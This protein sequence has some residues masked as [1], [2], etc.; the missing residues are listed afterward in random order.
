[1]GINKIEVSVL[2]AVG[3]ESFKENIVIDC[4]KVA[5]KPNLYIVSIG[6]SNYQESKFNLKYAS[7]DAQD[8]ALLFQKN[9]T[10]AKVHSKTLSDNE[11]TIE[12]IQKI[13]TF[14]DSAK[15]S[16]HVIIF[17]AGHGVL[18]KD[19][20]YFFASYDMDFSNPLKSRYSI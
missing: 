8:M 17:I 20:D 14:L 11:V 3:A 13:K 2:N 15:I 7:K 18:D 1:V 16:D 19:F 6:T 4:K 9:K 5:P 10:Y 12:N